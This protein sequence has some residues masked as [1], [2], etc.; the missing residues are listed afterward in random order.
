M[1]Y[2]VTVLPQKQNI[3]APAGA[4]LPEVLRL[5][6]ALP[7]PAAGLRLHGGLRSVRHP[8]LPGQRT[9]L[10]S[11]RQNHYLQRLCFVL[12]PLDKRPHNTYTMFM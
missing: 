5:P 8:G 11:R 12:I 7:L 4:D 1:Q 6:R 9:S 10:P 3:A 2:R